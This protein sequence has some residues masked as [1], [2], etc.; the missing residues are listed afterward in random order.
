MH[1]DNDFYGHRSILLRAA[2]LDPATTRAIRAHVQHGWAIGTGLS[3]SAR[4][5]GWL[6]RLVWS[7][8]NLAAAR[9]EGLRRV[10]AIGAPFGY[11]A[12]DEPDPREPTRSAI[13][14]PHHGWRR[15]S[16]AGDHAELA[17]AILERD[18]V[19]TTICLYWR[20]HDDPVVRRIYEDAGFRVI[21]HGNIHD[22]DFLRRQLRE[23]RSHRRVITNRIGTAVWYG[24]SLGREVEVYGPMF[25]AQETPAEAVRFDRLQRHAW[26]ELF[27][28]GLRG[29]VAAEIAAEQLGLDRLRP[30]DELAGLLGLRHR[31][32]LDR[33]VTAAVRG[34]HRVRAAIGTVTDRVRP[35]VPPYALDDVPGFSRLPGETNAVERDHRADD[36][37]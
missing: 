31:A 12:R 6:P 7:E 21:T 23:L 10:D 22:D 1:P 26:P 17:A 9:R 30:T 24:A 25:V 19:D 15:E 14:Y 33:A 37:P 32:R 34:E 18:G 11:L 8:H 28:G 2:G 20:E 36:Q 29:D 16:V 27:A 35:P 3:A 4:L 13:A 5:V